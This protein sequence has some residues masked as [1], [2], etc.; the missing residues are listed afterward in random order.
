MTDRTTLDRAP[1]DGILVLDL[2][3]AL[4]GPHAGQMLGDLGARVI[5][6]ENPKG[7]D[8]TR[9]WGP[10]FVGDDEISTYFLSC[11]RNKE[12]VTLDLKDDT[13]RERFRELVRRADVVLENFRPGVMER[14][15]FGPKDLQ[16]LNER[17]IYCAISGFGHDGPEGG[18]AGYD[19]IA[20]GESGLMSLTGPDPDTPTKVGVPIGDL[21]AGIH[22]AYG[23]VTALYEREHTGR[24]R[25]VRASLLSSLLSVH[26]FQG[27]AHTIGGKVPR[28]KGNHHPSISPYGLFHAADGPV[29]IAVGSERQ[30][31]QLC[32]GLSLDPDAEGMATNRER[33]ENRDRVTALLNEQFADMAADDVLA[34]LSEIG[35]PCGRV[36][37]LDE[38]YSWDQAASQG[39]LLDVDHP[40]LGT[41]TLTGNA[42][43]FDDNAYSGGR[44]EHRYPPRLGEHNDAVWA[45][46]DESKD[47]TEAKE[48]DR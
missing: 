29:Q 1:L 26:A 6:I 4:A 24:G 11:N 42:L 20:Q 43:R 37:T 13:D 21:L 9:G 16:H 38:V 12:S 39:M 48:D 14:L 41:I 44:R 40:D 28:G 7:G 15:G 32:E 3:R 22:A 2:S 30:W 34:R 25:I 45:W 5:K 46:L 47:A 18:R 31:R 10:P 8:D 36:R 23:I 27:T 17:L 19:Q 35:I 33:V